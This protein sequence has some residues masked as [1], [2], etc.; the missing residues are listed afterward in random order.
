MCSALW[1]RFAIATSEELA[2]NDDDCAICWDAM[3]SARKL[4]CGHLFH[5]WDCLVRLQFLFFFFLTQCR[6]KIRFLMLLQEKNRLFFI[7]SIEMVL[8]LQYCHRS[9]GWWRFWWK[10]FLKDSE[11][12]VLTQ[13]DALFTFPV[14]VRAQLLLAFLAGTG[15]V[16]PDLS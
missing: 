11:E 3:Q 13:R 5:K 9:V 15:H 7:S 4:P 14:C 6:S 16:V 12:K 8:L 2:A 1:H 10:L